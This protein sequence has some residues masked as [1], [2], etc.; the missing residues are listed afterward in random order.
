MPLENTIFE[1][2]SNIYFVVYDLYYVD[3]NDNLGARARPIHR[4]RWSIRCFSPLLP[5]MYLDILF[6]IYVHFFCF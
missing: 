4:D 5:H 2:S 3:Q 6:S 1:V